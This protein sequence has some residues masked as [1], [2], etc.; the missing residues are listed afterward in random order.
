MAT[1]SS[2]GPSSW[3]GASYEEVVDLL[4]NGLASERTLLMPAATPR[5]AAPRW[6]PMPMPMPIVAAAMPMPPP[7][8]RRKAWHAPA[9]AAVLGLLAIAAGLRLDRPIVHRAHAATAALRRPPPASPQSPASPAKVVVV[10]T[11]APAAPTAVTERR[12]PASMIAPPK[13]TSS[14]RSARVRDR[15]DDAGD[16]DPASLLDR[17]LAPPGTP[18]EPPPPD[19]ASLLDRGLAPP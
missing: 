10:D 7:V 15:Q 4:E 8:R 18:P 2:T 11:P 17:A 13:P 12:S 19:P 1:P 5:G 14:R 6:Q 16:V 9:I 3:N